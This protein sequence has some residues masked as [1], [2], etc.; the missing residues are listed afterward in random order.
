V[1]SSANGSRLTA[2]AYNAAPIFISTNSGTSWVPTAAPSNYWVSVASSADGIKL[3]AAAK[4]PYSAAGVIYTSAD[5]GTTWTSN[6]APN[7]NWASVASSADGRK[8]WAA[9][10]IDGYYGGSGLI[11]NSQTCSSPKLSITISGPNLSLS[12]LVPSMNFVLQQN[13]DLTLT[14][15]TD[16]TTPPTLNYTNLNYQ[17]TVPA[18]SGAIFYRLAGRAPE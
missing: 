1:A 4:Y 18:S 2:A 5:A 9:A 13:A 10:T 14:N 15:W 7:E 8:L 3:V 11:Y 6:S 16:V 12:W 17:V